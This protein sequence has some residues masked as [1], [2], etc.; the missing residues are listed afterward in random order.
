VEKR[1]TGGGCGAVAEEHE[2]VVAALDGDMERQPFSARGCWKTARRTGGESLFA[3]HRGV[4]ALSHV[5][6]GLLAGLGRF[7]FGE[8]M[9]DRDSI[10][11]R[12]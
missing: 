8:G 11:S 3:F 1:S 10:G 6:G 9:G 4:E 7:G 2:E 12:E 5:F